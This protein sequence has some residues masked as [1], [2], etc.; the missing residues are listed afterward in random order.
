MAA[1]I[2][3][4]GFRGRFDVSADILASRVNPAIGAAS[5]RLKRWVTADVYAA[6][7]AI[8]TNGSPTADEAEQLADLQNA[9]AHLAYHF[10]ISGFNAPLESKGVLLT[11]RSGEG[12][13][14]IRTYLSPN[15]T[16]MLSEQMIELAREIAG[17]YIAAVDDSGITVVRGCSD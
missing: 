7:V 10:A 13:H 4:A 9:E 3:D 5:R 1:L 14:E 11:A 16:A 6:T 8:I 17:P 12:G 15:Q 2:D